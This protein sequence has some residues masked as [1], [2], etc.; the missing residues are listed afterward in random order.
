MQYNIMQYNCVDKYALALC[1]G[2]L[3]S[4]LLGQ[5]PSEGNEL[6]HYISSCVYR[7]FTYSTFYAIVLREV[8]YVEG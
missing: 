3:Y 8:V 1:P 7:S 2:L 5:G 4:P 6:F